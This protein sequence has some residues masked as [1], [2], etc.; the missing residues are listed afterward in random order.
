LW[1]EAALDESKD[2]QEKEDL[3]DNSSSHGMVGPLIF[4]FHVHFF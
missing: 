2:R 4:G 3:E 1:F